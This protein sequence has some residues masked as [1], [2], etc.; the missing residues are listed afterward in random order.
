MMGRWSRPWHMDLVHE[1]A[2]FFDLCSHGK[3]HVWTGHDINDMNIKSLT[4]TMSGI[5]FFNPCSHGKSHVWTGCDI[6]DMNI[7]GLDM[8]DV[9]Y[10]RGK[11]GSSMEICGQE[12]GSRIVVETCRDMVR[13]ILMISPT[14]TCGRYQELPHTASRHT[15][16]LLAHYIKISFAQLW[17]RRDKWDVIFTHS[18]SHWP[19][20]IRR[21]LWHVEFKRQHSTLMYYT[22][23]TRHD[24][25]KKDIKMCLVQ[26]RL[27]SNLL[28][29]CRTLPFHAR[30]L[31]ALQ[32]G[33]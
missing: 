9:W 33:L 29:L 4:C 22:H 6:N 17:F 28:L 13:Q 11:W 30:R 5:H 27:I 32:K 15:H 19:M 14:P 23:C 2:F 18:E 16:L 7:E 21:V 20:T 3:S 8:H 26:I 24:Q 12:C 31:I 25:Y 10:S 1:V